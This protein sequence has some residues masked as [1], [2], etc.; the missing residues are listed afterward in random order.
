MLVSGLF[1]GFGLKTGISISNKIYYMFIS[2]EDE[3]VSEEGKSDKEKKSGRITKKMPFSEFADL[4]HPA[5]KNEGAFES[6]NRVYLL[7]ISSEPLIAILTEP[8]EA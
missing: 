3:Q 8:P 1:L 4:E 6:H 7:L 2:A 5:L